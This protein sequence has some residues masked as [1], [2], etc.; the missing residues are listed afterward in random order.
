MKIRPTRLVYFDGSVIIFYDVPTQTKYTVMPRSPSGAAMQFR[1]EMIGS[2]RETTVDLSRFFA[3]PDAF[4]SWK[5]KRDGEEQARL[6]ASLL[7]NGR[8][9]KSRAGLDGMLAVHG[10]QD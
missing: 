7:E 3:S 4:V 10:I 6:L 5:G 9:Y 1:G 2:R 8:Y